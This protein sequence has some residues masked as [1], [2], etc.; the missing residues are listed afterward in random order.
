MITIWHIKV[1]D[2]DRE[3]AFAIAGGPDDARPALAARLLDEG[4]YEAVAEIDLAG[5]TMSSLELAYKITQ[6]G[7]VSL[8]W[9]RE[10][11]VGLAVIEPAVSIH[12]GRCYGRR[13]TMIGDVFEES[14]GTGDARRVLSRHVVDWI[15][16]KP[17][18]GGDM[19]RLSAE[20]AETRRLYEPGE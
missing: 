20:G 12:G 19:S 11:P 9:S 6:N 17:M 2:L 15:G 16:F 14:V 8:S 13:S 18:P 3:T 7:V 1:E 5:A 10:P 4:H